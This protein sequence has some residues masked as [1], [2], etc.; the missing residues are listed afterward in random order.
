MTK[1]MPLEDAVE[2]ANS[3]GLSYGQYIARYR[4]NEYIEPKKKNPALTITGRRGNYNTLEKPKPSYVRKKMRD[5]INKIIKMYG[6]GEPIR[7]IA[8][9]LGVTEFEMARFIEVAGLTR[10]ECAEW[11]SR[12]YTGN[13]RG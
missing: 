11:S 5:S 8:G 7:K 13:H 12:K 3:L 1:F 10:K 6:D 4:A 9:I 2:A